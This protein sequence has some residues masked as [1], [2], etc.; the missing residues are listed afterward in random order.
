MLFSNQNF[1]PMKIDLLKVVIPLHGM[2]ILLFPTTLH[3]QTILLT[4]R[5][6]SSQGFLFPNHNIDTKYFPFF[7]GIHGTHCNNPSVTNTVLCRMF[8]LCELRVRMGR[9]SFFNYTCDLF[10]TVGNGR[11][12]KIAWLMWRFLIFNIFDYYF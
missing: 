3:C 5:N 4:H 8:K 6:E 2:I 10:S 1:L 7:L 12:E 9:I 11:K